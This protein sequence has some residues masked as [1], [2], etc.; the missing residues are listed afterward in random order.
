MAI[1]TLLPIG[2][3]SAVLL[4]SMFTPSTAPLFGINAAICG[5]VS[6]TPTVTGVSPTGGTT[7]GGTTVTITGTSFCNGLISV[8]FG[9][10]IATSASVVDDSHIT[11]VSPAHAAATVDVTVT[12]AGGTSAI[13]ASD[14]YAY[15]AVP[16]TG[17]TLTAAPPNTTQ[18]G[19]TVTLTAVASGCPNPLYQFWALTPGSGSYQVIQPY[20][21][22]NTTGGATVGAPPGTYHFSVWARDSSSSGTTTVSSGSFDTSANITYTL[23]PAPPCTAVSLGASP[24]S[25]QLSGTAIT[26]TASATC[27]NANPLYQ[28]WMLAPGAGTWTKVKAYST[29]GTFNWDSSGAAAGLYHFT[30]WAKDASSSG[31]N[32]NSLGSWDTSA[33]TTY[34][35][36]SQPCTSVTVSAVP[37]GHS[38]ALVPVT[39]T[40]VGHGCPNPSFQYWVRKST[41]GTWVKI[42]PYSTNA[43]FV[44]TPASDGTYFFS[45]WARDA[46]STGTTTVSTGTFDAA[47]NWS[48]VVGP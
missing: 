7:S 32:S 42:R 21:T 23:T 26:F 25:P 6:P 4:A 19:N 33:N 24:S 47:G 29:S 3:V 36:T 2:A 16:C 41:S 38:A 34:T 11:A 8:H 12:T 27:P 40:A 9:A 37:G 14:H 18:S 5:Y 13:S 15:H 20:S 31:S 43:Q 10:T 30:V 39:F 28:F 44:W 45:V 35:L 48:Y 46:S 17:V 1:G 22:S